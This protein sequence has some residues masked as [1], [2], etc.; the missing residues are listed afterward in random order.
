MRHASCSLALLAMTASRM[1]SAV[2]AVVCAMWM[3]NC[4]PGDPE[5]VDAQAGAITAQAAPLALPIEVFPLSAAAFTDGTFAKTVD[6]CLVQSEYARV[7][8]GSRLTFLGH[9]LGIRGEPS[10]EIAARLAN[11]KASVRINNGPWIHVRDD[12]PQVQIDVA[13]LRAGGING[14]HKTIQY[15]IKLT[16]MGGLTVGCNT[17]QFRF[18]ASEGLSS[19]YRIVRLNVLDEEGAEILSPTRFVVDDPATWQSLTTDEHDLASGESLFTRRNLLVESPYSSRR[20]IAACVDCHAAQGRD[21]EY[22]SYSNASIISR[23]VFHG[24]G[25]R[26][27]ELIA[28]YVRSRHL[29]REGR[30]WNPPYQPGVNI[31]SQPNASR[32]WAAGAGLDA[33]M[34]DEH[35]QG[36]LM[37]RQLFKVSDPS[38]LTMNG[39]L[40]TIQ[41]VGFAQRTINLREMPISLQLPDWNEWLPVDHPLDIWQNGEPLVSS[42]LWRSYPGLNGELVNETSPFV[43]KKK[44]S[45]FA[46]GFADFMMTT[47]S[48]DPNGRPW[49]EAVT[50][51]ANQNGYS[52]ERARRGTA[53]WSLV[54]QWELVQANQLESLAPRLYPDVGEVLS[55]PTGNAS[56]AFYLAPHFVADQQK[57]FQTPLLKQTLLQGVFASVVWY[58]LQLILNSSNRQRAGTTPADWPYSYIHIEALQR[59]ANAAEVEAYGSGAKTRNLGMLYMATLFKAVQMRDNGRQPADRAG[60]AMRYVSP[61]WLLTADW[62]GSK[63]E[64]NDEPVREWD[65]FV[66]GR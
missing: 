41:G 24:L 29:A 23:S 43:A 33:V 18:N 35:D 2:L 31:D 5:R 36:G 38:R 39:V 12:N 53:A 32:R 44:M 17:L 4:S 66:P 61:R 27:G 51:V 25:V 56:S 57:F 13:A 9:R 52:D 48:V 22:Y 1:L 21:L 60:W 58:H 16:D 6:L 15:S 7:T 50:D 34:A 26:Q 10:A 30:P 55:W 11:G 14:G 59:E 65:T 63:V 46:G 45:T 64:M 28:S 19:G 62:F 40:N 47:K 42:E 20:L 3:C 49:N 37:L 8:V 54:K